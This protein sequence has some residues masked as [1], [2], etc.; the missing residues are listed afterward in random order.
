MAFWNFS[1][2]SLFR[3]ASFIGIPLAFAAC[4]MQLERPKLLALTKADAQ[5]VSALTLR[6]DPSPSTEPGTSANSAW[7]DKSSP[8]HRQIQLPF[9]EVRRHSDGLV[10][11]EYSITLD[12]EAL[13]L[14][15]PPDGKDSAELENKYGLLFMQVLNGGD[16]YLNGDWV[17]GLPQS[18]ETERWMWY[19]PFIMPLPSHLLRTDGTPNVLTVSQTSQ[20]PYISIAQPYFGT[21]DELRRVYGVTLFFGTTL[22]KAFNLLCLVAGLFL[23]GAWIASPKEPVYALAGS[24]SV[25]WAIFFT[26]ALWTEMS[27]SW[28]WMWRWTLYACES[29][30]ISL[31]TL[32]VLSFIGQPLGKWGRCLL[33][34]MACLAPVVYAIGGR[35]TEHYL[36]MLWTP[37]LLMFYLYA[38]LR[39]VMYCYKTRHVPACILLF[40]SALCMALAFHDYAVLTG[41]IDQLRQSDGQRGWAMLLFEHIYLAHLGMPLLL[42]VMGYILLIQHQANISAL[43]NSHLHLEATL[44]QRELDLEKIHQQMKVVARSEATL[45]ERERIYQDVHDG[46]GSQ[47]VKAIFSLR[48]SGPGLAAVEHNLQACLRDLRLVIDAHQAADS[49]VQSAVFSFCLTQELHLEGSGLTINYDVGDACTVYAEPRVNLNVLRVLQESL[50]NTIQHSGASEVL[51]KVVLDNTN[52]ILSITDNGQNRSASALLQQYT[53][54][55]H[56]GNKGITGL[57][58]RAADIGGKYTIDITASGTKVQLSIPLPSTLAVHEPDLT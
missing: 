36:D 38:S 26:L 22:A 55:G 20:E 25:L 3:I 10:K 6:D 23:L 11:F 54:Y 18:T 37:S 35:P 41:M 14:L 15:K 34:L 43:E 1:H 52:L 4:F 12:G 39:L 31:M 30:L 16:F 28:L 57:A 46:I 13:A 32:F 2:G 47:L 5:M 21:L 56:S 48:N 44:Q 27:M 51:I 9:F 29:G 8:S 33:L 49:D 53:L 24:A 19:Q 45:M 7:I 17:A 42:V 58:L 40:Q 50:S